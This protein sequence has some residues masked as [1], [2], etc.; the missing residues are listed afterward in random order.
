MSCKNSWKKCLNTNLKIEI[1]KPIDCH[2]FG[3]NQMLFD[4]SM[5]DLYNKSDLSLNVTSNSTHKI[6]YGTS[7]FVHLNVNKPEIGYQELNDAKA[8]SIF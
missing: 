3:Q 5:P 4:F 2:N 8:T 1:S 7:Y 6:T